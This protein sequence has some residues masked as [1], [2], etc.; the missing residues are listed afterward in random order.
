MTTYIKNS[1]GTQP[2]QTKLVRI[3]DA[4]L[5]RQPNPNVLDIQMPA[6]AIVVG[7]HLNVQAASND[8]GT[9][10]FDVGDAASANR[11]ANDLSVKTTG[12]KAFTPTGYQMVAGADGAPKLRLT[13]VPANAGTSSTLN[14][15]LYVEFV[16]E[17]VSL[18]NQG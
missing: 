9:D 3:T 5:A 13:R 16:V 14:M 18:G 8:A 10:V 2:I 7:G 12:L 11:L 17:G 1:D 15:F 4:D 6:G